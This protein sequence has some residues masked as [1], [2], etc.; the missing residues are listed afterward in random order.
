MIDPKSVMSRRSFSWVLIL[1]FQLPLLSAISAGS[2]PQLP[3]ASWDNLP[4]WR[5]FNL[6]NR[7]HLGYSNKPFEEKDF[8]EISEMGFNFVRLAIDYRTYIVD[9]DWTRFDDA[10][11]ANMDEVLAWGEAY[12]IHICIN[13]HRIPGYT[14]ASPAEPTDLWT[15]PDTQQVAADH[16][17]FFAERYKDIPS[18]HLSFNLMNEPDESVTHQQYA[19]VVEIIAEAIR[20]HSPERLIICDGTHFGRTPVHDLVP[21]RVA[22]ST[23][24]YEPFQLTHYR[25]SWV[26]GSDTW[27]VPEWPGIPVSSYLYGS[28]KSEYQSALRINGPFPTPT[29]LRIRIA[30][31]SSRSVLTATTDTGEIYRHSFVPGPGDGDWETV[32]YKEEWGIYQNVYNRDYTVEIPAGAAY[33]DL[34]NEDGDWLTFS[35]IGLTPLQGDDRTEKY[36]SPGDTAWGGRQDEPVSY[37]ANRPDSPFVY[38]QA[39]G[40]QQLW[41]DHIKTWVEFRQST[42][43]G[44]I[45]GEW[46]C[47][48]Q[49]PHRVAMRWMQDVLENFTAADIPW[50]LWNFE[51]TFGILDS[52]RTD[53]VYEAYKGREIDRAMADLLVEY[54]LHKESYNQWI[55]RTGSTGG[56][57]DYA[58]SSP[59]RVDALKDSMESTT[60]AFN[61]NDHAVGLSYD[62]EMSDNL[63][64]WVGSGIVPLRS[65][66]RVEFQLPAQ[67]SP[68]AYYRI[69][70]DLRGQHSE[71]GQTSP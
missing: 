1:I 22:Q 41:D 2:T 47:Y 35:Q 33:V 30:V 21:L 54:A 11:F 50:A 57:L 29:Q 64:D 4:A 55:V 49:T 66:D 63:R 60:M 43:T 19:D 24:G 40:S 10:W 31:V 20:E 28:L 37:Y 56:I 70:F 3:P 53:V 65:I 58:M 23:R 52:G 32:V 67:E 8:A 7:F 16:W 17:A 26:N 27:P 51:G 59:P 6:T 69:I 62:L 5:G 61:F 14:V 45:A 46:G 25:A 34:F 38:A 12:G 68:F 42:G 13:L 36:F 44:I 18:S 15:N 71:L 9:G 48:N 39:N